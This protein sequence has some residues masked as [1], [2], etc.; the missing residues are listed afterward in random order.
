MSFVPKNG[1]T[2]YFFAQQTVSPEQTVFL[3]INAGSEK[4]QSENNYAYA[5][6]SST[7]ETFKTYFHV[8]IQQ[9]RV[10]RLSVPPADT[11]STF[12]ISLPPSFPD[13]ELYF[14]DL[15]LYFPDLELYF[16]DLVL[17]TRPRALALRA[18]GRSASTRSGK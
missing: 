18:L 9:A 11:E 14:P 10:F 3:K 13:L 2:D 15:E 4:T 5:K 12:R 17:A 16:P 7:R 1:I 8:K 6:K